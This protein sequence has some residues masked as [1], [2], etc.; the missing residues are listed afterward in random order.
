MK[1]G[2]LAIVLFLIFSSCRSESGLGN[3]PKSARHCSG[4]SP[5]SLFL[6]DDDKDDVELP[7]N[8]DGRNIDLSLVLKKNSMKNLLCWRDHG[9]GIASFAM[10]AKLT[11][12]ND[13]YEILSVLSADTYDEIDQ[14]VLEAASSRPCLTRDGGVARFLG[15][16]GGLPE[17]QFILGVSAERGFGGSDLEDALYWYGL[18]ASQGYI[19][20]DERIR[21][22]EM[23]QGRVQ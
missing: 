19:M 7:F 8:D 15:C 9:D 18:A 1:F 4:E 3:N 12:S 11:E 17:A 5:E 21:L 23:E 14:F 20:A 16:V 13:I 2:K 6:I 22:I 10:A